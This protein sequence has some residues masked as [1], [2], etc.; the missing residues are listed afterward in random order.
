MLLSSYAFTGRIA[1]MMGAK[2]M[3]MA[4]VQHARRLGECTPGKLGSAG[5]F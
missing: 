5:Q 3:T 4:E 2:N 1:M